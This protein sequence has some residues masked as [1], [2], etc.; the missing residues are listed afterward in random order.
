MLSDVDTED[1]DDDLREPICPGNDIE[2]PILD[3]NEERYYFFRM[4]QLLLLY[5][6]C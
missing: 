4:R 6:Y 1:S 3:S 5:C 2:F